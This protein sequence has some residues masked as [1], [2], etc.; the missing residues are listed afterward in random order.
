MEPTLD[1]ASPRLAPE[2]FPQGQA[3]DL[4]GGVDDMRRE[5]E[6]A[7]DRTYQEFHSPF[8]TMDG[9]AKTADV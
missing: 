3:V 8:P 9:P 2:P 7:A 6:E 4:H 5:L 1:E